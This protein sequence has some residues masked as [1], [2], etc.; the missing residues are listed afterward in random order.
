MPKQR[1]QDR[2]LT[3]FGFVALLVYVLAC[4][5]S[6]SPDGTRVVFP[7]I[8]EK[9]KVTSVALYDLKKR[10]LETIFTSPEK[11]DNYLVAQ[12]L[13]DGKQV[14]VNGASFIAILPLGSSNPTR[15]IPMK[16]EL[17]E[18]SL[19]IPPP[20]IGKYQ[21]IV[22][23]MSAE[24]KDANGKTVS[25]KKPVL[26]R[27]N[28]ETMQVQDVTQ[29]DE[30]MN[31]VVKGNQLYYIAKPT[32]G[33]D[34]VIELGRLDTEKLSRNPI[35]QLREEEYGEIFGFLAPNSDG[36]R[37]ALTAKFEEAR[38]ILLVKGNALEKLIPIMEKDIEIGNIEWAPDEKTLYAAFAK[39]M[40]ED[41]RWQYGI[42]EVPVNGG[43]MR[44]TYLF[45]GQDG[46]R[47]GTLAFQIALSLDGRR[48]AA[49]STCLEGIKPEDRALYLID[50]RSSKRNVTKIAIPPPA[51]SGSAAE[52]K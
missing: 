39:D 11:T 26:L 1:I 25:V 14:L 37:F 52:G 2:L 44:S 23:E 40:K 51:G 45:T 36:G 31:I 49:S 12:W 10:T 15:F 19:I 34:N 27:A 30:E 48:I 35:S 28:L 38:R 9:T 6:F 42:M 20:V 41:N 50:L 16:E 13:P 46:D 47:A 4:R 43:G 18:D 22:S 32:R 24:E 5:P 21:F 7:I 8:E 33:E 29:D 17:D 3:L